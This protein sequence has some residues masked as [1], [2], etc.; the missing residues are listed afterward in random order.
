M[1]KPTQPYAD[2]SGFIHAP[3]AFYSLSEGQ[4]V[5]LD[6]IRQ[7]SDKMIRS[8]SGWRACMSPEESPES[9]DTK[10]NPSYA[11]LIIAAAISFVRLIR[12]T[13]RN[14]CVLLACDT[15]PTGPAI[16]DTLVRA[17][18]Y[19]GIGVKVAGVVSVCEASAAVA[20]DPDTG[21]LCFVTASHNPRGYNGLKF[22][23]EHGH[24]LPA[25]EAALLNETFE[26]TVVRWDAFEKLRR[27]VLHADVPKILE[28]YDRQA[29]V[30]AFTR[31]AYISLLE[32]R[33]ASP[34]TFSE[35][36]SHTSPV[37]VFADMNGSA[38]S[39]GP[40]REY[41]EAWGMRYTS[42]NDIPGQ[43]VHAIEPEGRALDDCRAQMGGAL[44][45][46]V[47]DND[48]DRGNLVLNPSGTSPFSL[49]AQEVFALSVVAELSMDAIRLENADSKL[50]RAIVVNGPTSLR[51]DRLARAFGVAVFRA[52]VGEA[53]IL[54]RSRE[55]REEG[56]V[57]PITGE[58]SNGGNITHP[59][60]I[61]DPLSTIS[62]LIR[63]IAWRPAEKPYTQTPAHVAFQALSIAGNPHSM[64]P[65][66]ILEAILAGLPVF[67][68]TPT[69][70]SQARITVATLDH[71]ALKSAYEYLLEDEI[72]KLKVHPSL[73][74]I[75]SYRILNLEATVVREGAGNRDPNGNQSGGLSV[76][77]L[78]SSGTARAF[79]WMRGS[80]T[81][82][83]L[84]LIV[85][86]EGADDLAYSQLMTTQAHM[87]A[88]A[89][90]YVVDQAMD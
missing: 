78:D 72:G 8:I 41:L 79:M 62:S 10:L 77:L 21:G 68:T 24:V 3:V 82:P 20:A 23:T 32:N 88:R 19:L 50:P 85:D 81:E 7:A 42:I 55:L 64:K 5:G 17:F 54:E 57:V 4:R 33:S 46:Y 71:G 22:M 14:E 16:L 74:W 48:G 63:L 40:D 66:E 56:Y 67:R 52:E 73:S 2:T 45:G 47:P 11:I 69:T 6:D 61:R 43:I 29:E 49:S 31:R 80:R 60:T 27:V 84:R 18:S 26:S 1:Q 51:I 70:D 34:W 53:N 13:G 30:R 39:V 37:S 83:V 9:A 38:R 15:R 28:A 75:D 25:S 89:S 58:G 65:E 35:L 87:V 36:T 86:M 44:V 76:H 59:G 90:Q 12:Q